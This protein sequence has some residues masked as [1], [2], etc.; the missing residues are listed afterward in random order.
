[1]PFT[2]P[3]VASLLSL[4]LSGAVAAAGLATL[5]IAPAAANP[6]GTGLVISEVYGG[7]GN[8]GAQF[9]ND[10]VELYNPTA[11]PVSVAGMSVQYRSATGTTASVTPLSGSVPARGHYLVQQA[12]GTNSAAALPTPDAT[13]TSAMS[14]NNGVVLLVPT[15][16]PVATVGN[17]A[18]SPEVVDAVGYGT[19]PATFETANT[20]V[21]LTNSTAATRTPTG[22]DTDNNADDFTEV[23]PD[24]QNSGGVEPPPPPP[25][26]DATI[27]AIQGSGAASPL[28]GQTVTTEGVVTAVYPNGPSSLN[29]FYLQ[30]AGTGGATDETPGASDGLFVFGGSIDEA[31]LGIAVGD[32]VEVS[33]A[34]SEFNTSTQIT[35]AADGVTELATPLTPVTPL[36][37][38]YPTTEADREAHEGELL[39]PT[40]TFT[41]TNTFATNQFGEIGLATGTTPLIQPTEVQDAQ[42]GTPAAVAADNARRAVTLDDGSGLNYTSTANT[43]ANRNI[44]LPWLTPERSIRVGARATLTDSVVLAFAFGTWRFQPQQQVTDAGASVATFAD[45]RPANQAPAAVGGDLRIATFN[46]LNYFPTTGAEYVASG[47][48]TCTYFTDRTGNPITVNSCTNNGPRGAANEVNLARQQAKTVAAV[49]GLGA[50]VVGLEELENSAKFGK[51]RDFAISRLVEALNADAGAGTWAYAP[52]PPPADRPTVAQEDVIRTGFIYKPADVEL[53][54]GSRILVDETNFA[55]AREPLA[56]A[57][58]A[59]GAPDSAAFVVVV[60]HLKS[61]GDS[62]PPATG[63]NANG[64]QGAFNGDRTRQAQALT[65]FASRFAADRGTDRV[66]LAGDF[67]SYTQE[68]PMQVLYDAGYTAIESDTEGEETYS[69]SG[70][71]GSLDHVLA[72]PAALPMVTGADIW[73][74]SSGESVAYEY[75]RFNNNVTDFYAANQF[76]SSDHDPEIVGLDVPD[77]NAPVDVQILGTNDF[78]G[79]LLN[80]TTNGEAGAAVLSGA[81]KQLRAT[82][83]NTVFAA[84]G[85]LIGASTFESFIAEDK[86]T[87]DA[88]NEAGL[89]VSAAGN[90][91]F[92]QGYRDLVDRVLAPYDPETNPLGGAEWK[93]LAANVRLR[94]GGGP[95]LPESWIKDFGPVEVGFVGAVTE[96]LPS[97]VA[98]SG[99][100]ELQVTGIVAAANAAA[101]TLRTQGAD[102]VVLLVHEG[103]PTTT[104][105]SATDPGNAFGRIVTGVDGDIDAIVSGHTHLAYNHAV[106]VPE[107]QTEGRA[108]TTRPVVSAGQYGTN[109][110]RLVFTLDPVT[111]E[112][113]AKT[114][115]VLALKTGQT[116]NYPVDAPTKAIVDAAVANAEALGARP[117][118]DIAA[119]FNR[120]KLAGGATENRGGESTLGNLVAEVQQWATESPESGSA[121]IAFMNPGGLR[122]DLVGTLADGYPETVT[123]KQAAVVQPFAN[124]LVNMRLT[125]AQIK[126][127]LEQQWQRDAAGNVPSR[128]FL[129]LGTSAGF[130]YTYDP[131]RPEGDRVTGMQLDG[132]P[133]DSGT[134]YSVTVNSFLASGGD[135]FRVFAQGTQVRDTGRA[136]LQ[137]MVDYLAEFATTSPLRPDYTQRSVGVS[138]PAGAQAAYAPGERVRFGLSSLAFSTAADAKDEQVRVSL[139]DQVLGTFPVD[140]TIGTAVFDEYGTAAVDVALPASTPVGTAALTVTGVTTGTTATVPVTVARETPTLTTVVDPAAPTTKTPV[141]LTVSLAARQQ[142]T[143]QVRVTWQR[144][145]LIQSLVDGRTTFDLGRFLQAGSYPVTVSYLG[146]TSAEPVTRTV[147]I[148][149]VRR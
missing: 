108:V 42:T 120:A 21:A 26:T 63:D 75:S 55:N 52:T 18:G 135:N 148:R 9:T 98:P 12:A 60:N 81:V 112:V 96:D 10:F 67:N 145:S 36:A 31:A 86:P 109:L 97:L 104:L 49:N 1:M 90:H 39:A 129:R 61:K 35:P 78:H 30:T 137:A 139:G 72:S 85:D 88:L 83:A 74:I 149:V 4:T 124:T 59:A 38:A 37:A 143:G 113:M 93:Y 146:S 47:L 70:L 73:G 45:T 56:Q 142:V 57:F 127:A 91:E 19:G 20:G 106:P 6:A 65:A 102:V 46:V 119:P 28:V 123:Y 121:Q 141:R 103:A 147:T 76:R 5:P 41:V 2:R 16:T 51:D 128:P 105:A 125:G 144:R 107:W 32:S 40:D 66:F 77:P 114:Q 8:T 69:F 122:A 27:A 7:G 48:G 43:S 126:T 68:D 80:N 87:I 89:E 13:G 136:D 100:A 101:D 95:A 34:V 138:F 62:T 130:T 118:G 117:L 15:T 94:D 23:A 33:G 82:N 133:L 111:G 79:R 54:G 24:P 29:G 71:S 64:L 116:A 11:A 53:V 44:P 3:R 92:D 58:K 110:N 84:A 99:I 132:V 115:D 22:A 14:G 131:A 134:P 50:S 25:G 17:V 140:N